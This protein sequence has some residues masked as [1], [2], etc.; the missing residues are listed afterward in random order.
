MVTR[1]V[2]EKTH[3]ILDVF[4]LLGSEKSL[5]L[6]EIDLIKLCMSS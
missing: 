3:L 1:E 6:K 2:L 4:F 5:N